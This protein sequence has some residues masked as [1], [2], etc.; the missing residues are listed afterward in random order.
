MV[1]LSV[2]GPGRTTHLTTCQKFV[3]KKQ[4]FCHSQSSRVMSV[5]S[6]FSCAT[7]GE[8]STCC[9]RGQTQTDRH[10]GDRQR[11][12]PWE[13]PVAMLMQWQ[14]SGATVTEPSPCGSVRSGHSQRIFLTSTGSLHFPH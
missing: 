14:L 4:N 3:K 10:R 5:S 6:I 7:L 11:G 9:P 2:I 13:E 1:L 12:R 8:T